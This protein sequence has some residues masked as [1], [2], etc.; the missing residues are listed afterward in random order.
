MKNK[1]TFGENYEEG[2]QSRRGKIA[3]GMAGSGKK[4]VFISNS[5]LDFMGNIVYKNEA[6]K[7]EGDWLYC[8]YFRLM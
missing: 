8:C 6:E 3:Y 2:A 5:N 4:L 1:P 7:I